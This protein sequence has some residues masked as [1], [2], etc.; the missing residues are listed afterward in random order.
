MQWEGLHLCGL[1]ISSLH[2]ADDVIQLVASS[3]HW[4]GSLPIVAGMRNITAKSE[5]TI[6]SQERVEYP[7]EVKKKFKS[8]GVLFM[9]EERGVRH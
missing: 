9:S 4:T 1:G 8:L 2:F 3:S 6:L 5:A 7:T